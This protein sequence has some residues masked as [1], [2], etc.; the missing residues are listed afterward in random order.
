MKVFFIQS[1]LN[2][3]L[4]TL[5]ICFSHMGTWLNLLSLWS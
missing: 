1:G 2:A 3:Q 5:I 4:T